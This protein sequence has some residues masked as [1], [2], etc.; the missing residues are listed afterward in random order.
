MGVVPTLT[1]EASLPS[2][3]S[4]VSIEPLGGTVGVSPGIPGNSIKPVKSSSTHC[5]SDDLDMTLGALARQLGSSV[6]ASTHGG[7]GYPPWVC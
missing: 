5:C 3:L 6:T 4:G 1:P 7:E 2:D